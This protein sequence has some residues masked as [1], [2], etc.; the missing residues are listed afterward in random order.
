VYVVKLGPAYFAG[1]RVCDG[2]R[3]WS[4]RQGQAKRLTHIHATVLATAIDGKVVR[5]VP[6]RGGGLKVLA[7]CIEQGEKNEREA[8]ASFLNAEARRPWVQPLV[9]ANLD[10]FAT[11]IRSGAHRV[12][13]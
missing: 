5:L 9:R 8:I 6:K 4:G 7:D 12:K 10:A 1:R 11:C 2:K 13:P 3:R